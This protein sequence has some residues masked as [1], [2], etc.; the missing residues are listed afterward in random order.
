MNWPKHH[1]RCRLRQSRS[2]VRAGGVSAMNSVGSLSPNAWRRCVRSPDANS[3]WNKK[4]QAAGLDA[5]AGNRD[6]LQETVC[7]H[8]G[9]AAAMA[10]GFRD[11]RLAQVEQLQRVGH[12]VGGQLHGPSLTAPATPH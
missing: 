3:G 1:A 7:S 5:D 11:D 10:A 8:G 12:M 9:L 2:G 6:A 4:T